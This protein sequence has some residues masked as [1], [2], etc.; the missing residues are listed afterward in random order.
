MSTILPRFTDTAFSDHVKNPELKEQLQ[1]AGEKFAMSPEDVARA[2]AYVLEQ[3]EG[4][5]VGE[6]TLRS[7][8]QP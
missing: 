7:K 4:V 8:M 2:I 3:P 6:V 1:K 5:N